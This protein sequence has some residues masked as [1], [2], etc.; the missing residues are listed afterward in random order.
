MAGLCESGNEPPG[1]LKASKRFDTFEGPSEWSP[2][3]YELRTGDV[4]GPLNEQVRG[5]MRPVGWY[6]SSSFIP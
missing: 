2:W 3:R 6:T 4:E 1:S 5:L